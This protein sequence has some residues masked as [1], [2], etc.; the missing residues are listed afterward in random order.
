MKLLVFLKSRTNYRIRQKHELF[1]EVHSKER[2]CYFGYFWTF[3]LRQQLF[4]S[5]DFCMKTILCNIFKT[6][7][8]KKL[9]KA[10]LE[11]P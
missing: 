11:Y 10:I 4:T 3:C 8:A 1:L 5:K 6:T 7:N 9:V 2:Q